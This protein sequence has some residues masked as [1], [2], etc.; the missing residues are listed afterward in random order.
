M[1]GE[2]KLKGL[3]CFEKQQIYRL[4]AKEGMDNHS[5]C[6]IVGKNETQ[7]L[8]IPSSFS[9]ILTMEKYDFERKL[10]IA[11]PFPEIM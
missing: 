8:H 7:M 4:C 11:Q 6:F 1:C 10:Q 3:D 9:G 5:I 2:L